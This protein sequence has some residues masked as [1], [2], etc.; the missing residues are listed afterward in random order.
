MERPEDLKLD[1]PQE[2]IE[3]YF[4]HASKIAEQKKKTDEYFS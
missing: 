2:K 3:E 1:P 4:P